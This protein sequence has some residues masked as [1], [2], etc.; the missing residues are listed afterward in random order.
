MQF[1]VLLHRLSLLF[2][3]L[4]A[5]RFPPSYAIDWWTPH[6]CK[7]NCAAFAAAVNHQ[8]LARWQ[9]GEIAVSTGGFSVGKRPR[10][11]GRT[12]ARDSLECTVQDRDGRSFPFQ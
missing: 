1:R 4:Q 3:G 5:T 12:T 7:Y 6:S 2:A 11:V 10:T 8:P 9:R